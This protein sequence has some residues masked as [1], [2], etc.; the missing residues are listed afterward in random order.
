GSGHLADLDES[1]PVVLGAQIITAERAEGLFGRLAPE[2]VE[3]DVE[4]ML[5]MGSADRGAEVFGAAGDADRLVGPEPGEPLQPVGA[6]SDYRNVFCPEAV[7][8]Q[9]C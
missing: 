7:L 5:C 9:L 4:R 1:G 8:G 3:H 6:A 2:V